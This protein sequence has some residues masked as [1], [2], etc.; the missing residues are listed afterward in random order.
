MSTEWKT[1]KQQLVMMILDFELIL[2]LNLYKL[3]ALRLDFA[4]FWID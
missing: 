1:R 4:D 3:K 2:R